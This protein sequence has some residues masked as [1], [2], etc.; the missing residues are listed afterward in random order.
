[1]LTFSVAPQEPFEHQLTRF[2]LDAGGF[3]WLPSSFAIA[4][5]T[6]ALGAGAA[7]APEHRS[8]GERGEREQLDTHCRRLDGVVAISYLAGRERTAF[9]FIETHSTLASSLR[10]RFRAAREFFIRCAGGDAGMNMWTGVRDPRHQLRVR[11]P[12]AWRASPLTRW[13]CSIRR[14]CARA[15]TVHGS[16]TFAGAACSPELLFGVDPMISPGRCNLM[17]TPP[18]GAYPVR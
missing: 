4:G 5:G 17:A 7:A 3:A 2:R 12:M 10:R 1:M 18:S 16:R 14:I 13:N 8:L 6:A 9:T 11:Q 15:A